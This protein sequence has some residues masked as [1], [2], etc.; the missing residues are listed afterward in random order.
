MFSNY[1][2]A[3]AKFSITFQI[4]HLLHIYTVLYSQKVAHLVTFWISNV[5]EA[6]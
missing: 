6:Q 2:Y 5:A 1:E 4:K 3:N